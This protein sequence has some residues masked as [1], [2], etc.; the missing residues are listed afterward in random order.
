MGRT[1]PVL[2]WIF[3]I[4]FNGYRLKAGQF[5]LVDENFDRRILK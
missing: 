2:Q 3:I 4:A 5:E 1:I